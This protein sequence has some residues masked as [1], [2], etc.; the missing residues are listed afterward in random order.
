M[1]W[2]EDH[3]RK[4]AAYMRG[5]RKSH[6]MRQEARAPNKVRAIAR[7]FTSECDKLPCMVCGSMDSNP[8]SLVRNSGPKIEPARCIV[9]L[10]LK[11]LRELHR[12]LDRLRAQERMREMVF[13]MEQ[14]ET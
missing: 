5:W 13:R 9:W 4:H 8:A 2:A 7:Y 12:E 1:P 10:C 6:P 14:R 11:H 3:K